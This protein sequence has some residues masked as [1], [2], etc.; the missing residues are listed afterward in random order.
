MSVTPMIHPD[1]REAIAR[2]FDL[3]QSDTGQARR[4][5]D[6]LLA[7]WNAE[8]LGGFDIANLFSLD[9]AIAADMA[10]VFAFLGSR[11]DAIYA[12]AFGRGDEM[13][14][15]IALWRPQVLTRDAAEDG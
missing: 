4:V 6:F 3:A 13:Q 11:P 2:L 10:T 1:V 5:A 12:D 8:E 15:L 9:H 14:K 7:W